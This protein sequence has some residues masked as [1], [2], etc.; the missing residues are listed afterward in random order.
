M[1]PTATTVVTTVAAKRVVL[2]EVG[3]TDAPPE[4]STGPRVPTREVT[5]HLRPITTWAKPTATEPSKVL[6]GTAT[7]TVPGPDS[8]LLLTIAGITVPSK[9]LYELVPEIDEVTIHLVSFN[10]NYASFYVG[11]YK[12]TYNGVQSEPG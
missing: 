5:I 10:G 6:Y 3:R 8:E 4:V 2:P 12:Y 1:V 11:S 7:D 9:G